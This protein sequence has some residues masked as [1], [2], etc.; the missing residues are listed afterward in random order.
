MSRPSAAALEVIQGN[1]TALRRP[2]APSCLTDEQAEEWR[3]IVTRMPPNWFPRETHPLLIAYCRHVVSQTR[4]EQLIQH[5]ENS[6]RFN[7]ETY[8]RLLRARERESKAIQ[9][10]ATRMRLTQLSQVDR[11]KTR[12]TVASK[13][14]QGE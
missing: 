13:P 12:G 14:W 11:R 9:N 3:A 2:D 6:T 5:A 4:I 7:F 1:V 10:L 8:D